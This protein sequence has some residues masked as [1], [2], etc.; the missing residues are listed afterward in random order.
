MKLHWKFAFLFIGLTQ[1]WLLLR[2]Q[3][4]HSHLLLSKSVLLASKVA[5]VLVV[6]ER[7]LKSR[8]L[9]LHQL[10]SL[11]HVSLANI[12]SLAQDIVVSL[13]VLVTALSHGKKS[14]NNGLCPE[15]SK[16]WNTY[17]IMKVLTHLELWR[18]ADLLIQIQWK[19]QVALVRPD[20]LTLFPLLGHGL[21]IMMVHT[22][23][24]SVN[25]AIWGTHKHL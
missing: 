16:I 24:A 25:Q 1:K 3:Q 8:W 18:E 7:L 23:E 22:L 14:V 2:L 4:T 9:I 6:L 15:Q 21:G 20:V 19:L 10:E 13:V 5:L 12:D 11:Q 17:R